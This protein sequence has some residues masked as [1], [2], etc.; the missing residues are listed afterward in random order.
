[1]LPQDILKGIRALEEIMAELAILGK[2]A[3]LFIAEK[4]M[5]EEFMEFHAKK[6]T[7]RGEEK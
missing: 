7:E 2:D 3:I 6:H 5:H 1:M 4:G